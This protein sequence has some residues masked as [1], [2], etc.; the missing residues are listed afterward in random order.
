MTILGSTT[1]VGG[2]PNGVSGGGSISSDGMLLLFGSYATNIVSDDTNSVADIYLRIFS[3]NQPPT[4]NAGPDQS[5]NE[6]QPITLDGSSSTDPDGPADI[7]SY[8]WDFG[9]GNTDTG[10]IVIHTFLDNGEYIAT[11]TVTDSSGATDTD[12]VLITVNNLAPTLGNISTT[13]D[14]QTINVSITA[15]A[16]FIDPG[17]SDTH[18]AVWDWGDGSTSPG[19]VTETNGSGTALDFHTHTSPGV[20]TLTLTLTDNDGANSST[21]FQYLVIYDPNGGF[22]TGAGWINSPLGSYAPDMLLEG[23]ARFG[24]VSKYQNGASLPTGETK[25]IYQLAGFKFESTAYDWLVVAGI[26]AQ[27][28]GSGTVNGTGDYGFLLTA[29]DGTEDTFRI[30]IWD[31]ATSNVIYDNQV[32]QEDAAD[33]NTTLGGGNIVIHHN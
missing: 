9:D 30:K 18:T 24:F 20:Y 13:L 25:F 28:K 26:K 32:G 2:I 4:A 6:G 17:I 7:V 31:K 12:I 15:S 16:T 3:Q 23:T 14:P 10:D 1:N 5:I 11:L 33:A 19:T 29:H 8:L 21:T 22:V 27:Y